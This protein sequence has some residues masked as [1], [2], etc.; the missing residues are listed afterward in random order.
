MFSTKYGE[1][2]KLRKLYKFYSDIFES[3]EVTVRIKPPNLKGV[4][5]CLFITLSR[6]YCD[7]K[8]L[9]IAINTFL[10][11]DAERYGIRK[12]MGVG[13]EGICLVGGAQFD[14]A[15]GEGILKEIRSIIETI[16]T[17]I[18]K[19]IT[20]QSESEIILKEIFCDSGGYEI[21][22]EE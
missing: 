17:S 2:M 9:I 19:E 8:A 6:D 20:I 13:V 15:Q 4:G 11:R 3:V 10:W 1:A 7:E 14:L 5:V 18:K 16:G 22:D 12:S 21:V